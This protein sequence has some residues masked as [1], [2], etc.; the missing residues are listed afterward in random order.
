MRAGKGLM[1]AGRQEHAAHEPLISSVIVTDVPL[2]GLSS[3]IARSNGPGRDCPL[4]TL[5]DRRRGPWLHGRGT[6]QCRGLHLTPP[7]AQERNGH[8]PVLN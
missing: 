7:V 3:D 6:P 8:P 4:S 5:E 2:A 1:R